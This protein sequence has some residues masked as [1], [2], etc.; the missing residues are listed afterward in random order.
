MDD[1]ELSGLVIGSAIEVYKALGPGLLESVYQS[2]MMKEL[3]IR[4]VLVESEVPVTVEYK[5]DVITQ[6]Y[7]VDMLIDNQLVVELKVVDRLTAVHK[8]Q[9]LTYLR[10]MNKKLGLLINFNELVV[11]NGIKRLINNC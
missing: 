1:N 10:L 6:A 8:A 3:R 2:C 9:L 7:R 4:G 5:G 11:K